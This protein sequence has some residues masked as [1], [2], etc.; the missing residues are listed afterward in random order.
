MN[1][2]WVFSS[3]LYLRY[4]PFKL[5]FLSSITSAIK[6]KIADAREQI[7]LYSVNAAYECQQ[8]VKMW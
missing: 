3:T 4:T 8:K 7:E 6:N 1:I 5:W 2:L